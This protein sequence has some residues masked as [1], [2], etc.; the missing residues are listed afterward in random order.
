S[1]IAGFRDEATPRAPREVHGSFLILCTVFRQADAIFASGPDYSATPLSFRIRQTFSGVTGMS[2][3]FTPRCESASTTAFT[4]AAGAPTVA[5]SPTP[6]APNGWCGEGV[7]VLSVSHLGVSIAV[8]TRESMKLPPCT[9]PFSSYGG[10]P[11][12]AGAS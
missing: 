6:F 12:S 4:M 10:P 11:Y 8:G 9:L 7:T 1:G 2:M 3:C 5:D